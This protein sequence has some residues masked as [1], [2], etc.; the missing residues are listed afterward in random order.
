MNRAKTMS[1]SKKGKLYFLNA[2]NV[3]AV[4]FTDSFTGLCGNLYTQETG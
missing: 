2:F 1:G 3:E 4:V